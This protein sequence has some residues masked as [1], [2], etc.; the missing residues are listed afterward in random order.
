MIAF[1]FFLV[2]SLSFVEVYAGTHATGITPTNSTNHSLTQIQSIQ[3]CI[4]DHGIFCIMLDFLNY[5]HPYLNDNL[6]QDERLESEAIGFIDSITGDCTFMATDGVEEVSPCAASV[7]T[8]STASSDF[9][10]GQCMSAPS[11]VAC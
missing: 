5:R 2:Y 7:I 9:S 3:Q 6:S 10:H 4:W 1:K 11:I 8:P